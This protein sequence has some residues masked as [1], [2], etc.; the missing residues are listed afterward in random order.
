[1]KESEKKIADKIEKKVKAT[2]K[3][4][5]L[6][7]KKD[8]IAVAASGGK[9]STAV[10]H[11]LKKS[12]YDV[13][14]V[15]VD[16]DMGNY[17]KINLKNLKEFCK[18]QKIPLYYLSIR[19]EFKGSVCYLRDALKAKG[20]KL[21]SCAVCGVL[22]RYLINKAA[23]E[24]KADKLVTGH[25][26]D[27]EAQA[28]MMN[29]FRNTLQLSARLGPETGVSKNKKFVQ[30]V[31]PMYFIREDEITKYSKIMKFPVNYEI[32]PCSR[33]VFRRFVGNTL[34]KYEKKEP[35]IKEN[36]IDNFLKILPK[37]KNK[38]KKEKAGICEK[39]GEPSQGKICRTCQIISSVKPQKV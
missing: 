24:L 32:C 21:T 28:V 1:M 30:R 11:I 12:G 34:N 9:D 25:N 16:V 6:L 33:E 14:A 7:N 23:K 15:T 26:L 35:K 3:K 5:N 20:I 37:L 10:L 18:K 22:R 38:Y 19:E 27:D 29:F 36:I 8:K 31:K 13:S 2:I 4:Y 39:C 17:T